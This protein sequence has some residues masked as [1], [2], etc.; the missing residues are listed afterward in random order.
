MNDNKNEG[1]DNQPRT[2]D[3]DD[4][5]NCELATLKWPMAFGEA[6]ILEPDIGFSRGSIVA[7]TS[8]EIFMIHKTQMQTFHIQEGFLA[9]LHERSIVFPDD[10][11]LVDI[12][13]KKRSWKAYRESIIEEIPKSRWPKEKNLSDPFI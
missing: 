10:D 4:E 3:I 12:M 13:I 2:M 6:C 7:T 5:S 8:C 1:G 9:R 11:M